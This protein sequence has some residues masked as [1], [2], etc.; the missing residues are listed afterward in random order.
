MKTDTQAVIDSLAESESTDSYVLEGDEIPNG[1]T[2]FCCGKERKPK[3][4]LKFPNDEMEYFVC[5]NCG[6]Y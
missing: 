4:V 6:G 1:Y 3:K 5:P 2:M